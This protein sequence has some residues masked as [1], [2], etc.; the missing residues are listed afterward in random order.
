[1]LD[2]S[3]HKLNELEENPPE[4]IPMSYVLKF[5][6]PSD[7]DPVPVEKQVIVPLKPVIHDEIYNIETN[8]ADVC[9]NNY[10]D[11]RS[12]VVVK[13][14]KVQGVMNKMALFEQAPSTS[15]EQ[16]LVVLTF[17]FIYFISNCRNDNVFFSLDQTHKK[18]F[19]CNMP[20]CHKRYKN[21]NG[22]KSHYKNHH[23]LFVFFENLFQ[24]SN[25]GLRQF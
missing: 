9:N 6:K 12:G 19:L 16:K 21:I 11:M 25:C 8:K 23:K 5:S 7:P 13:K 17:N 4:C 14:Q 20:E 24:I 10:L 3:P 2:F 22:I 18:P 15:G 1:M